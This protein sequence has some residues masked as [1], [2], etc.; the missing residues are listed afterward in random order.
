MKENI[1]F[2]DKILSFFKE[3]K[4]SNKADQLIV[5]ICEQNR[6]VAQLRLISSDFTNEDVKLLAEWRD[7]SAEWFPSQFKV[8]KKGTRKWLKEKLINTEDRILFWVQSLDGFLIGHMGL[9]RF[10]FKNQTCEIDNVIR[11]KQNIMPGIMTLGLKTLL[12]WT[13]STLG[14]KDIYL[15]VFFD[16]KKAIVLY[17]RCGLKEVGK[18]P[19][20]RVVKEDITQ[21][22]EISNK[23][24]KKVER[25]YSQMR[26]RNPLINITNKT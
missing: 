7:A 19:L 12:N 13:F 22:V 26:L 10:D 25:Y 24:K 6:V 20:K 1:E 9:Y 17:Q 15:R 18:I 21:W 8:T 2:R 5:P 4:S 3:I 11:G 23:S 14:V 16:N